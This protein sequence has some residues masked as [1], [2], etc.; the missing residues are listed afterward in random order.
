M[1][2]EDKAS[3]AKRKA[4]LYDVAVL[5]LAGALALQVVAPALIPL[6]HAF[7]GTDAPAVQV[8]VKTPVKAPAK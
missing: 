7:K 2:D 6:V 8:A 4:L 3:R 5:V 1:N